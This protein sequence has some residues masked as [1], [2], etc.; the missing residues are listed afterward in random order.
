[1]KTASFWKRVIGLLFLLWKPIEWLLTKLEHIEFVSDQKNIKHALDLLT[2]LPNWIGWALPIAGLALIGW[3]VWR[4]RR[5]TKDPQQTSPT[6]A[7]PEYITLSTAATELYN[8]ALTHPEVEDLAFLV[9]FAEAA[10]SSRPQGPDDILDY[11]G[12][13]LT[14]EHGLPL[15]GRRAPAT[16]TTEIPLIEVKRKDVRD[17]ATNLRDRLHGHIVYT[18]L[19]VRR[20]EFEGLIARRFGTLPAP[21]PLEPNI[22]LDRVLL[23]VGKANPEIPIR[24]LCDQL[25]ERGLNG[26]LHI[27]GGMDWRT[28]PPAEYDMLVRAP[29]RPDYWRDHRI[30]MAG[31]LGDDDPRGKAVHVSGGMRSGEEYYGIWFD[32]R[33]I[34]ALWPEP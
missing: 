17:G 16:V 1:M 10:I 29:I 13:F 26:S 21:G 9:G 24:K 22:R 14:Q 32:Q 3:D 2:S 12:N 4:A 8:Y 31:F 23:K 25:R 34:D 11:M 27:F 15:R 18:D 5:V 30:E 33:E 6:N 20:A 19:S 28:T 7:Q